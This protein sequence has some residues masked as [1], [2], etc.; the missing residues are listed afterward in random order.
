MLLENEALPT[1]LKEWLLHLNLTV[2]ILRSHIRLNKAGTTL[3]WPLDITTCQNDKLLY[4]APPSLEG[5]EDGFEG[6]RIQYVRKAV[7]DLPLGFT[8]FDA[9]HKPR[10]AKN[11]STNCAQPRSSPSVPISS[12]PIE[13]A[14]RTSRTAETVDITSEKRERGYCYVNINYGDSWG[15]YHPEGEPEILFNFKGEPNYLLKTSHPTTINGPAN[16]R[17]G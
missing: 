7:T 16:S 12:Y 3:R 14:A 17:R 1:Q 6:E 13:A 2:P 4:I 10:S 11:C 15:Y 8:D 9:E 5:V